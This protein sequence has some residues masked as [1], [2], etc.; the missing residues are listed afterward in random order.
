MK[1]ETKRKRIDAKLAKLHAELVELK[2]QCHDTGHGG[3]LTGKYGA[4]TGNWSS[5]DDSYWVDF[6][7]PLCDKR[8]TE[9]QDD[10]WFDR[11]DKVMRT[12][13]GIFFTRVNK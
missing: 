5:T 10:V 12:K 1:V 11:N 3:V 2:Q 6:H 13:Q 7:C 8:W 4:N 9:D